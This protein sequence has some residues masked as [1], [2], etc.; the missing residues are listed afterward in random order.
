MYVCESTNFI[1]CTILFVE[2]SIVLFACEY[3]LILYFVKV[4]P[5]EVWV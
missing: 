1:G 3:F 5:V 4:E 2:F